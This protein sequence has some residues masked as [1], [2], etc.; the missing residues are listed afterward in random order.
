MTATKKIADKDPNTNTFKRVSFIVK[1]SSKV[2]SLSITSLYLSNNFLLSFLSFEL[3]FQLFLD[4]LTRNYFGSC[5]TAR[6]SHVCRLKMFA[7]NGAF[8]F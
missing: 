7:L 4:L 5:C 6:M 3:N 2:F 1:R 8:L